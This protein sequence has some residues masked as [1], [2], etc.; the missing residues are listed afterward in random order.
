MMKRFLLVVGLLFLS[1]ALQAQIVVNENPYPLIVCEDDHDGYAFF[2]L[3]QADEDITLGN[4]SLEVTYHQVQIDAENGIN[5]LIS[6][7][8]NTVQYLDK[9]YARITH[10]EEDV[11]AIVELDLMV[12]ENLP[13]SQPINLV[14]TDDNGDGFAVFDLTE[15]DEIVLEGLNPSYFTASYY[16]SQSG[17]ELGDSAIFNPTT[18]Q[19]I[20]NPQTIYVRVESIDESCV[21][22]NSFI[23][24]TESLSTGA[25]ELE[26]LEIFPNPTSE[27]VTIRSS[28]LVSETTV[29]LFDILG[30][31]LLIE[32]ETPVNNSITLD[33]STFKTGVYF[34]KIFFEE[35]VAVQKL[36]KK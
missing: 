24:S 11:F 17:A 36:I 21:T 22:V 27:I 8:M 6:P 13:V 12:V 1:I 32:K 35:N 5:A 30:K 25:Y 16:E 33:V 4:S 19:N 7:Y 34:V 14:Q 10:I 28:E 20:E 29:M 9:V 3:H 15:N 26:N 18:Y 31:V 23:I 2:D